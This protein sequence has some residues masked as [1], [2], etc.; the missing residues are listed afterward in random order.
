MLLCY[1]IFLFLFFFC[2]VFIPFPHQHH[3][4]I[5][6]NRE[7]ATRRAHKGDRPIHTRA[8]RLNIY[9]CSTRS[10]VCLLYMCAARWTDVVFM[11]FLILLTSMDHLMVVVRRGRIDWVTAAAYAAAHRGHQVHSDRAYRVTWLR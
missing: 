11:G 1:Y 4:E 6:V 3:Q 8:M 5:V 2:A 7:A 10:F 9:I